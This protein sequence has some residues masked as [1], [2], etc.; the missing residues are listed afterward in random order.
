M[1]NP[2]STNWRCSVNHLSKF[3]GP[4]QTEVLQFGFW[5]SFEVGLA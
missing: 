4:P 5:T 2:V 3:R 1:T